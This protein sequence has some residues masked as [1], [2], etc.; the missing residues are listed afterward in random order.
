MKEKEALICKL[1]F[2]KPPRSIG[3][4]PCIR[5]GI[6]HIEIIEKKI[7]YALTSQSR[8]KVLNFNKIQF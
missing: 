2:P 8:K 6:A 3:P 5:A 4:E 7:S 1:A